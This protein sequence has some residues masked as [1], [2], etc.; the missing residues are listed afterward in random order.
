MAYK[1]PKK[2]KQFSGQ[3]YVF[4]KEYLYKDQAVKRVKALKKQ[5]YRARYAKESN[6]Y[7]GY[8]Y[9]VYKRDMTVGKTITRRERK[10]R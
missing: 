7:K 5:G 4:V 9:K 6:P 3:I 10:Y 1:Y 2:R 8:S